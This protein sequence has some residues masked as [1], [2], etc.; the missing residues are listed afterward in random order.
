[1]QRLSLILRNSSS[2]ALALHLCDLAVGLKFPTGVASR[3][4]S[5][6]PQRG[7]IAYSSCWIEIRF[8][9][10]CVLVVHDDNAVKMKTMQSFDLKRSFCWYEKR[11]SLPAAGQLLS[12]LHFS[13]LH[14]YL[15]H[16]NFHFLFFTFS[17]FS[18]NLT[19]LKKVNRDLWGDLI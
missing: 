7:G 4:A 5:F 19:I 1:M 12:L 8:L 16:E 14:F 9:S 17:L 15:K 11:Q 10:F 13:L 2:S 3:L 18:E 6:Y